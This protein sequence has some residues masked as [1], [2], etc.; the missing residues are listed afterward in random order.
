[1]TVVQ[2]ATSSFG[3]KRQLAAAL[4]V[5]IVLL[6]TVPGMQDWSQALIPLA[7]LLGAAGITHASL[8]GTVAGTPLA[9]LAALLAVL[10]FAAKWYPPMQPYVPLLEALAALFG[11]A[12]LSLALPTVIK[13]RL[14]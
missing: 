5:I 6:G 13:A 7:A 14:G 1:M 11:S 12:G 3:L 4:L 2:V 10:L 8:A 9:G